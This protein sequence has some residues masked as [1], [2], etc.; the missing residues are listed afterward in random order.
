MATPARVERTP[1]VSVREISRRPLVLLALL[2]I[3]IAA[4]LIVRASRHGGDKTQIMTSPVEARSIAL[5]IEATGTVEPIDLVEVKSKASGL[6]T[7]MPVQ[8]GSFVK[9]G[10][11]LAQIDPRDVENQYNQARAAVRAA[12][13]NVTV[14]TAA[15]LRSD[16]LFKQQ[17]IT[18]DEH[19]KA[20]LDFANAQ[21]QLVTA[22]TNL[23]LA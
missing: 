16:A 21:A 17:F 8:V 14:T 15:K 2:V 20:T 3:A 1:W 22:R 9:K 10:A 13:A 18:A 6:I 19:E 7:H 5:T 12:E 11:L 4:V 23:D